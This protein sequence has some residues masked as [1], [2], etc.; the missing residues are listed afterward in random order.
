MARSFKKTPITSWSCARSEK[1]DKQIG[2]RRF[3]RVNREYV[4]F[5]EDPKLLWELTDPWSWAKD[6]KGWH[7]LNREER[8]DPEKF[9]EWWVRYMRK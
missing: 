4:R 1:Q 8:A 7:T 5:G 6:G 9:Q 2:N 3:R